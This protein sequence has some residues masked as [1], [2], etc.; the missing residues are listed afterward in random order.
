MMQ[1]ILYMHALQ[2]APKVLNQEGHKLNV[3][4]YYDRVINPI[5]TLLI[6]LTVI[7]VHFILI[8]YHIYTIL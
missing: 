3:G 2:L 8:I 7:F 4:G 5:K 1:S 6:Y